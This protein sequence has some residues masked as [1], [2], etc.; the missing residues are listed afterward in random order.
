MENVLPASSSSY[1]LL[2]NGDFASINTYQTNVD[3]FDI[4][5][6]FPAVCDMWRAFVSVI[7]DAVNQFV[8]TK[9]RILRHKKQLKPQY[10]KEIRKAFVVKR[11][12]WRKY[13]VKRNYVAKTEYKNCIKLCNEL[14][15]N[16]EKECEQQVLD[17]NNVGAFYCF[18]NK[19]QNNKIGVGPCIMLMMMKLL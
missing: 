14:T 9:R 7:Y 8:P 16:Y 11:R 5:C 2:R 19:R 12:C 4:L 3:W 6:R 10:P 15:R 13:R 17:A 18:A 1:Y